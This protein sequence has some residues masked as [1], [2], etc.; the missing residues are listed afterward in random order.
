MTRQT[1]VALVQNCKKGWNW[2]NM[3]SEIFW[4]T[5]ETAITFVFPFYSKALL[6]LKI[7]K[8]NIVC[9]LRFLFLWIGQK[10]IC[11]FEAQ[12]SIIGHYFVLFLPAWK[13]H[14]TIEIST[15]S[16]WQWFLRT[17]CQI[18]AVYMSLVDRIYQQIAKK[19]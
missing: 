14:L 5:F 4:N 3:S 8:R 17:Q 1:G 2:D 7:S 13:A 12:N 15:S 16:Q 18:K 10:H 9:A 19:H 6:R 11:H